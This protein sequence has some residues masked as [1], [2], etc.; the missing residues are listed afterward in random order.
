[1]L[2]LIYKNMTGLFV[3]LNFFVQILVIVERS[4]IENLKI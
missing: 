4:S 1:M 2:C 3:H